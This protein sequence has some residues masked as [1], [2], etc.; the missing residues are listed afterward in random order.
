LFEAVQKI[1][2]Q[3][4]VLELAAASLHGEQAVANLLKVKQTAAAL[5]DR[6]HLTLNGFIELMVARLD[7]QPDEA[8]SPLAEESSDAVKILTIHKAKG[9]EFPVVVLPGLHQG[10]GRDKATPSVV[11][12]W[13]TG[14]YGVSLGTQHTIGYV[15]VQEKVVE[16]QEAER[17]R[18]CYVGMTRAKDLLLLSG[19]VTTRSSGENVLDWLQNIG[20]GDIGAPSTHQWTVGSSTILHRV[21]HAPERKS[22]RRDQAAAQG[23]PHLDPASLAQR[24]HERTDRWNRLRGGSWH[25]TPTIVTRNAAAARPP[26]ARTALPREVSQL[27]GVAAHRILE[28]WDFMRP[29]AELLDHIAPSLRSGLAAA[30]G[31]LLPAISDSLREIFTAFAASNSYARLRSAT[32][33]GREIPF[34]MPWGDGQVMEG[35]ID[36][37]Y[38]LDGHTWIA[39][40]KTDKTTKR[41][42][43]ARAALYADQAAIYREAA[44]KCLGL[45][46]VSFQFLF[47]RA[48]TSVEV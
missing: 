48:G 24:W 45:S 12:D 37:I 35:V 19:G 25:L 4:P 15:R 9:L 39:D 34:L 40:Y 10:S 17:K 33:L 13:S 44:I 43:Q 20:D 1:F 8:E 5:S 31:P 14:T 3:L 11:F 26:S 47:L 7:D 38:R 46:H 2:D 21:V 27:A 16:R 36:L 41:E 28:G 29:A 23:I 6:P 30:D 42:A 32:I 22:P 18:V